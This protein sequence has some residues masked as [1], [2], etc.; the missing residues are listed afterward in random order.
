MFA[1]LIDALSRHT[2]IE[3]YL[4]ER[5]DARNNI[6]RRELKLPPERVFSLPERNLQIERYM[7]IASLPAAIP[8]D[9]PF[10]FHSSYYRYC[11]HSRAVNVTTVHDFTYEVMKLRSPLATL[12]HSMQKRRAIAH[13]QAIACVSQA[14]LNDFSRLI[15][16][17]PDLKATV[18]PNAPLCEM[19]SGPMA[20]KENEVLY[21]GARAYHKNFRLVVDALKGTRYKLVLCSSPLS[22][23]ERNYVE[24]RLRPDQF[25]MHEY[26][27]NATLSRMYSTC[28]CL[29]YPSSYEGF[30]I[31]IIEA[32]QHG[33]PV[34]TGRCPSSIEAGGG[35]TIL[36]D[37]YT[38]QAILK[39]I[40][41]LDD[42]ALR[43]AK[44]E[45]GRANVTRFNWEEIADSY[46]S[47]YASLL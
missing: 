40:N 2:D 18:I 9:Q 33:Q 25:E 15:G 44:I 42:V 39:A 31:P 23:G 10:I 35:A 8:Q 34:I 11:T 32:Q 12:V 17:R 3:I 43:Q 28:R 5:S 30:G 36:I 21:V 27:D 7:N 6:F 16:E 29:V 4:L 46:A 37:N 19:L 47:L 1:R 26:P 14:T 45:A 20:R 41:S 38:P 22:P 13:S 24:S